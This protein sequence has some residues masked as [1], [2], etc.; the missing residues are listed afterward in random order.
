MQP[1]NFNEDMGSFNSVPKGSSD[2]WLKLIVEQN[3]RK[4]SENCATEICLEINATSYLKI[5]TSFGM[6]SSYLW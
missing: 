1:I 6:G 2:M 3:Q 5:A 4:P